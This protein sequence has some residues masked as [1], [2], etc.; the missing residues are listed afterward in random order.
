MTVVIWT[1]LFIT[2]EASM[3]LEFD[4]KSAAKLRQKRRYLPAGCRFSE[5]GNVA[6]IREMLRGI[7]CQSLATP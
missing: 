3:D 7:P 2:G 1:K 5:S 6:Q 4:P